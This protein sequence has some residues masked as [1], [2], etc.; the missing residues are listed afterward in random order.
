[1][2]IENVIQDHHLIVNRMTNTQLYR[3]L[4]NLELRYCYLMIK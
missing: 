1:M 2:Q 3:I 4:Q